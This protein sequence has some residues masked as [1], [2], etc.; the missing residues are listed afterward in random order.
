[1]LLSYAVCAVPPASA[2][3]TPSVLV[4]TQTPVRGSMP[5]TATAYGTAV[6]AINGGLTLSV[7]SDGRVL[8]L[9]VTPGEAVHAG[10]QL[11][12]FEISAAARS[13]YDQAMSALKLA[14][15]E[16]IR[17]ARLLSQQLATRD[18]L[19][20]ADKAVTDAQA[21]LRALEREYGGKP[22]QTL[23][24]PFDG[25]VSAI[26][27]A[28]GA[29]VQ[30]GIALITLT[31]TDGL[32][33]TVG[34]EAAQR[35]RLQL[36]Q[37]AKLEALGSSPETALDGKL[38][39]VDHVLNPTT[40][41]IDADV[42][43]SGVLLQGEAFRVRIELGRIEG[44]L[45]PHDAVL[46]DAH[47]AYLFQVAGGKA[48][49]VAVKRLGSDGTTSVVEGAIDPQRLLVTQGNYQLSDGM[50]V[51]V[52]GSAHQGAL[53]PQRV[54]VPRDAS[55]GQGAPVDPGAPVRQG[56]AVRPGGGVV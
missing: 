13:N 6:P 56:A 18:Q 52:S 54:S 33:V 21:A 31:R 10:Q 46:S 48:V 3:Q 35:H 1:M 17:I 30:P 29:R 24:A 42:A 7:Q 38:V 19:A 41:L 36:G 51:R 25:V 39:R 20:R 15:E 8:K 9:F 40:R 43:V 34:V 2:A 4:S 12:D 28:Q 49:R 37:S 11:L 27:V 45:V 44:W 5:D 55:A 26:P 50:A 32:V 14:R 23:V 47:G 16:R 53:V 22:R